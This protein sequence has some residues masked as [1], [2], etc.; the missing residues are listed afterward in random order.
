MIYTKLA[1]GREFISA[2]DVSWTYQGI[3]Q[4][5][6]KPSLERKRVGENKVDTAKE[7]SWL[8]ERL[9][10]DKIT[11]LISHDDIMLPQLAAQGVILNGF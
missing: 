10:K 8:H 9:T 7:L 6:Q 11:I 1:N 4:N 3:E 2:G 5:K